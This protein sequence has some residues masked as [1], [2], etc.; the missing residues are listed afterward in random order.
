MN[1]TSYDVII[2]G[3]SYAGLS[4]AMALGRSLRKV[5][6]IDSGK[7]CN[8]QT[9]HSHNFITHDGHT[10][11][12]IAAEAKAQVQKYDTIT[13]EADIATDAGRT[14]EGFMVS[15]ASGRSF[16]AKKLLLAT[17][18]KDIMPPIGGLA[19]CWGISVL[20]CPYCHGYEV[21]N[22]TI[23]LLA[24]GDMG[25]E[26]CKLLSNWSSKL[27]LLTNGSSTLSPE[28]TEK[29]KGRN[30]Q[31]DERIIASIEHNNG[32]MHRVKFADGTSAPFSAIFTR[33]PFEQHTNIP[34]Q[35]GC[36]LTEH[37]H[38]KVDN[39]NKTSV[40]GVFAAGDNCNMFRAVSIAVGGGTMAGAV[41][42]KE[43]ID[44]TF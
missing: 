10:P 44:E 37:G 7:P 32:V 38:I 16:T 11:S 25:F 27:T 21:K 39:F 4:A 26:F 15:T 42:N 19:E 30:I 23:G 5:L 6:V 3:G 17:G 28:Q 36:E 12:A 33:V 40:P 31:L 18:L 2:I 9:P 8:R 1:D 43:L 41:I 29:I 13:F 35:L 22:E 20:H 14:N 34:Q 24:N